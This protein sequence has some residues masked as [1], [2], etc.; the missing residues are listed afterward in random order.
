MTVSADTVTRL[1]YTGS[2]TTGPFTTPYF[3]ANADLRVVKTLISDGTETVLVL[4]TDYTLTGAGDED[5]G[6]LTLVSSL[7]S[8]YRL[9]IINDPVNSQE[10]DYPRTD[11]FPAASHELALDRRTMVSLRQQDLIDR[12]LRLSDGVSASGISTEFSTTGKAGYYLRF[13]AAGTGFELAEGDINESTFTASG[14]GATERSVTSKLGDIISVKDFGATGDGT[15]DDT[16]GVT[17]ADAIGKA[18]FVPNG[19]Y[20]TTLAATA[21]DGPY[22]GDGQIRDTDN[23]KRGKF[24][25]AIKAAP[26][27]EGTLDSISTAFNGDLSK[28]QFP[29]EHRITGAATLGQPTTGYKFTPEAYPHFDYLYNESGHNEATASNTGRTGAAIHYAR[30]Y[31]NGQGDAFAFT[32]RADVFSTKSGST[33]FLANPAAGLFNGGV[34]AQVDGAYLNAGEFNID[35]EGFDAAAIGWVVNLTRSVSTGAKSAFWGAFR[36]QSKGAVNVDSAFSATGKF[37]VGLDFAI[38]ADFDTTQAAISL[39]AGQRIYFNNAATASGNLEAGWRS[40][41]FNGDYLTYDSA[42][43]RLQFI[44]GGSAIVTM[45]TTDAINVSRTLNLSSGKVITVNGVQVVQTRS[46]GWTAMTGS[47]DLATAYDTASVTLPQLAGRV[48]AL[49]A[50]LT[51]HGLIGA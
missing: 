13:N 44:L 23:N 40:T 1:S 33:H 11:P 35:D 39:K 17:A 19:T 5:G 14:S 46:T 43:S 4:T 38:S 37:K 47:A 18:I 20:D 31:Q 45:H 12:S 36:A 16:T 29:V 15:T 21:L 2:G 3:L 41:V 49:Q 28:C 22:W 24:F 27:S 48:M 42:T 34:Y 51:G 10:T 9:T 8:S 50:A 26:S 30:V 32:A 6:A 7:S 25:A